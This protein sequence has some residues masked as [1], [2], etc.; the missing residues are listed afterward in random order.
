M[1]IF[2]HYAHWRQKQ[3]GKKEICKRGKRKK[4][5]Q[6]T[7]FEICDERKFV[8]F[9]FLILWGVGIIK[10]PLPERNESADKRKKIADNPL[11]VLNEGK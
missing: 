9:E 3:I 5:A 1:Q 6:R 2:G 8:S 10:S 7:D 11:L 4:S